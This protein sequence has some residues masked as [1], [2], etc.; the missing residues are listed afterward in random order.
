[1]NQQRTQVRRAL[2]LPAQ[3]PLLYP[4]QPRTLPSSHPHR[5]IL[6]LKVSLT[7]TWRQREILLN[8]QNMPWIPFSITNR[9]K[10]HSRLVHI[11]DVP[12]K[13][14]LRILTNDYMIFSKIF[15]ISTSFKKN[16]SILSHL[17]KK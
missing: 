1:M 13:I 15:C 16:N 12:R 4:P 8:M 14:F 17:A 10:L 6:Y 7:L 5:N 11:Q 2:L 3:P 9:G